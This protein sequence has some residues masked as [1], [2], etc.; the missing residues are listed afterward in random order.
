MS[1]KD[2]SYTGVEDPSILHEYAI[3]PSTFETIDQALY[4][5]V[6]SELNIFSET[7]KGF[8]KVP[9]LWMSAE[10]S[11]QIKADRALRDD[12]AE[13]LILPLISV[14][15]TSVVKSPTSK[16]IFYGNI[17]SVPD[18]KGGSIVV[19]R[20]INQDK[21][22]NFANVNALNKRRQANF[23]KKNKKVV[24]QTM[25]IP[26]PVYV[27]M[28]YKITLRC[29]YQQQIND[30]VTPFITKTGGINKF[31][32]KKDGHMFEGFIQE[33]FAQ[34][35]NV[36]SLDEEERIY[37]TEVTIKVLAYLIGEDKNQEQPK[38][39]VRENAVEVK[40]P[41]ERVILDETPPWID[42]RGFYRS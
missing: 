12:E 13:A 20:R 29:E 17:P 34:S 6:N 18:A 3:Q 19:A 15:R 33:D 27:D 4:D 9:V 35:N 11:H 41:R 8:K 21:T 10:R 30:M 25:S 26:M 32:L 22:S 31:L 2:K 14:D 7:N 40:I 37:K 24:Y 16:G 23:P 38:V 36:A 28:F 1:A 42:K 39:V 5:W